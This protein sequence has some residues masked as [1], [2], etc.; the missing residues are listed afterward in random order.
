MKSHILLFLLLCI[1][2][3]AFGQIG[4]PK[5]EKRVKV[6]TNINPFPVGHN[7]YDVHFNLANLSPALVLRK[8]NGNFREFS[9]MGLGYY[10]YYASDYIMSSALGS[11]SYLVH[12][13]GYGFG[14]MA[15]NNIELFQFKHLKQ[16]S[17]YIGYFGVLRAGHSHFSTFNG[18]DYI[19]GNTCS[20]T[21]GITPRIL[22]PLSQ[23]FTADINCPIY[24]LKSE[25]NRD[26]NTRNGTANGVSTGQVIID[27]S[28]KAFRLG[29]SLRI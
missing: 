5:F 28:T 3:L 12:Y 6:Y 17:I 9:L 4:V 11:A 16:L 7:I 24:L 15:E 27:P 25:Y 10:N 2:N 1:G 29:L 13:Q 8:A 14:A 18:S 19:I 23:R 22:I 21:A 20:V 26:A